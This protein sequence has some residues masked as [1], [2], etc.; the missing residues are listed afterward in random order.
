MLS[1]SMI[2]NLEDLEQVVEKMRELGVV[3]LKHG[4]LELVLAPQAQKAE[5][6]VE[7]ALPGQS[8]GVPEPTSNYEDPDLFAHVGGQVP[9]LTTA[10]DRERGVDAVK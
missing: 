3:R 7:V 8:H 10:E 2:E 9:Y 6:A 5:E 4:E 1:L